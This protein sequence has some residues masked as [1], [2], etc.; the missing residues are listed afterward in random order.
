M[1]LT[2]LDLRQ[3]RFR[4]GFR[5]YDRAQVVAFLA[6]VADDYEHALRETDRL[7]QDLKRMEALLNEH[8][9]HERNLRNTLLT[10]QKLSDGIRENAEQ[11]ARRLVREA[12]SRCDLL[13]QKTYARLDELQ[14][15]IDDLKMKRREAA[16]SLESVIASLRNSL[17]FTSQLEQNERDEKILLHRPRQSDIPQPEEHEST[18]PRAQA[19]S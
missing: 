10:A 2:P 6:G 13:L 7:Q 9:A 14:R 18:E 4:T 16:E 15:Q 3:Q 1:K 11:E 12:E 17:D 19:Q 8:R 5:G